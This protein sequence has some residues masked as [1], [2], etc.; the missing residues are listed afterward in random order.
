M[1]WSKWLNLF[2]QQW[3]NPKHMS[4]NQICLSNQFRSWF[5]WRIPIVLS[6]FLKQFDAT[7][8]ATMKT[9]K[10]VGSNQ[11]YSVIVV[12]GRTDIWRSF[13]IIQ[14][15][16]IYIISIVQQEWKNFSANYTIILLS[17]PYGDEPCWSTYLA[18]LT[19]M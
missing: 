2:L 19:T 1:R 13:S 10:F 3:C 6:P 7:K 12:Y 14:L 4:K 15:G 11:T 5:H 16:G 8:K 9:T 17:H 18:S